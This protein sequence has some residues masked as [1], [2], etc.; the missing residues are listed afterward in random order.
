MFVTYKITCRGNAKN[1]YGS[2]VDINYRKF[3]HFNDLKNNKHINKHLQNAY[4]KYGNG[5]FYLEI[6]NVFD[7]REEMIKAEQDLIDKYIDVSFNQSTSAKGPLL[8]GSAN[9]FFGKKHTNKTKE[10]MRLRKL[11]KPSTNKTTITELGIFESISMACLYHGIQ[12]STYY[13]RVKR[14]ATNWVII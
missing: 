7:S 8:Y 11:G 6:L 13:R 14:N 2:T 12:K 10:K 3:R 5:A 4:N 1:Y 9:G